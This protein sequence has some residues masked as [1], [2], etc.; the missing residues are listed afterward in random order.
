MRD[1][2]T[3][4][5]E[6]TQ[7][8]NRKLWM[9]L[10]GISITV[11]GIT[12]AFLG[13]TSNNTSNN[14]AGGS[15]PS[16]SQSLSADPSTAAPT[17]EAVKA[18]AVAKEI[19]FA[20]TTK[21]LDMS[22]WFIEYEI[23]DQDRAAKAS[24]KAR[25]PDFT[26][27]VPVSSSAYYRIHVRAANDAGIKTAW[28]ENYTVKLAEL[29]GMKTVEPAPSY[30]QTGWAKGSDISLEAAKKAIETAWDITELSKQ[31]AVTKCLPINSGEMTPKLLLPP[32]P[33]II[34][35]Q[36]TLNYMTTNWNGSAISIT[37][38]WCEK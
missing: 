28:S 26:A 25:T 11:I 18:T 37:Y 4:N 13:L 21:N 15:D 29:E 3:N 22:K 1:N 6:D 7:P 8:N 31:E 34:P 19:S 20:V 36:A 5:I 35:S 30:Y 27:T 24:G 10:A 38:L 16:H 14:P 12:L 17:I 33:S 32:L 23:T 2:M 9:I